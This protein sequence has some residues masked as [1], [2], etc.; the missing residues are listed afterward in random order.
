MAWVAEVLKTIDHVLIVDGRFEQFTKFSQP[1]LYK[2]TIAS[3]SASG[4]QAAVAKSL[5]KH[6]DWVASASAPSYPE[7]QEQV[8][9]VNHFVAEKLLAHIASVLIQRGAGSTDEAVKIIRAELTAAAAQDGEQTSPHIAA[10]PALPQAP[11]L[12]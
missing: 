2:L 9:Q 5:L 11:G 7:S 3:L 6:S 10:A 4:D 8:E 12:L 1:L